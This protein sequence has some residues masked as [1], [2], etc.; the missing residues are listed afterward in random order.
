MVAIDSKGWLDKYEIHIEQTVRGTNGVPG[1]DD[2]IKF[3]VI[4]TLKTAIKIFDAIDRHLCGD[5]RGRHRTELFAEALSENA[6]SLHK[7][8]VSLVI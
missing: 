1:P 3:T 8:L 2:Q 7:Y 4:M 5:F 6:F